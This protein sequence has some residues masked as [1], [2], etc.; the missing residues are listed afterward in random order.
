M[1]LFLVSIAGVFV[2]L[3]VI[4]YA[5]GYGY[6]FKTAWLV[7]R[8]TPYERPIPGAP[9]ILVLGDSTA[10]GTGATRST[11][12]IA[13]RLG[14]DFPNYAIENQSRNGRTIGGVVP[15]AESL[16]SQYALIVLQIGGNDIIRNRSEA[17]V[18]EELQ[19]VFAQLKQHSPQVV[20]MSSGNVGAAPLFAG[21][22]EATSLEARTRTFRDIFM[23]ES[24]LAGITYVDLFAEPAV[25]EVANDPDR[26]IAS[27]GLHP[28]SEGYGLWYKK[29]LP[30]VQPILKD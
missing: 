11:D 20:F 25:D 3:V 12:T 19:R 6:L 2:I 22:T 10:Y 15:V 7:L 14:T 16:T 26:Y 27:D 24:A 21:T 13:G 5:S 1:K 18:R 8:L 9:V 4:V 17:A 29:L 23:A 30:A 28:S